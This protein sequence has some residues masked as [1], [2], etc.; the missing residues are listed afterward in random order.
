MWIAP[1]DE[2]VPG[3]SGARRRDGVVGD[4]FGDRVRQRVCE[5]SPI[6]GRSETKF[7]V[8]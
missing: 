5:T 3:G 7:G 2:A 8:E 1:E 6:G 4:D